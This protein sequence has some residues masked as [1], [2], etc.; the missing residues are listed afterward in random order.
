MVF[1]IACDYSLLLWNLD[2]MMM[3]RCLP[4]SQVLF[5]GG[6]CYDVLVNEEPKPA[7]E[8]EL[9]SSPKT[10]SPRAPPSQ[11]SQGGGRREGAREGARQLS[12]FREPWQRLLPH[13]GSSYGSR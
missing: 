3:Q 6:L 8:K 2:V 11:S 10:L 4:K 5:E 9:C 1:H 7:L 12:M 13:I